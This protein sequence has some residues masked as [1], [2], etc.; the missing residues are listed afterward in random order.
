MTLT[1]PAYNLAAL[2]RLFPHAENTVF[3]N[4]AGCSPL[5][6]PVKRAMAE[7][8][9]LT[10][11]ENRAFW[12]TAA[13]QLEIRLH[14][15]IARLINAAPDE[16]ALVANTGTALNYVALSLPARRRHNIIICD[17]EFPSNVYP[18]TN[19]A[20][21]VGLE[22][23]IVS[24]EHGGLTVRRLA[25]FADANTLLVA[26]SAVE[27]LT[28]H[29]TDV[30]ALGAFCRERGIYFAVDG[31]QSLGHMPMDVRAANVD[32]LAAGALKSLMGP[33]GIGFLYV[34]RQL[35]DKLD[36]P[37]AGATS[38]TDYSQWTNYHL[39]F[40][41]EAARY[42]L[43]TSNWIGMAGFEAAL[44]M[45]LDLGLQH[46]DAWTTHLSDVLLAD[47]AERGF[48]A[49]TPRDPACHG[50]I[51]TFAVPDP[52]AALN[53]L[54]EQNVVLCQREGYLRAS[55]HCY[56]TV[57]DVLRIG[58]ILGMNGGQAT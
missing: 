19:L 6:L 56:N 18:W 5:A 11:G 13:D 29:R 41:P 16:I 24:P 46:I 43:G 25:E 52:K 53:R 1:A 32:F 2:R 9:E 8:I 31:I 28:G 50:P 3:L 30:A 26:A 47:L 58:E 49:L 33:A 4:H 40:R 17:K 12:D 21:R 44:T 35:L 54:A 23:R 57:D 51:V 37:V 27:F 15:T 22:V 48:E 55:S 38:V 45:L 7:A 14:A 34:R 20:R 10:S 42:A 36:M 39:D